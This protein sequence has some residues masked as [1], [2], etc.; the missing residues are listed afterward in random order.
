MSRQ[1]NVTIKDVAKRAKVSV[2]SA[3][4]AINGVGRISQETK[5]RILKAAQELNYVPH[6]GAR[7]LITKKNNIIGV[8]LPD[9]Y[10]EFFSEI[11][12]GID[13]AARLG[14]FNILLSSYHN[15]E[16]E[17][18]TAIA[19]MRGRVDGMVAMFPFETD[20]D[21]LRNTLN[22]PM[23]KIANS[24]SK[25]KIPLIAIDNADGAK[26]AIKHLYDCGKRKIA[27]LSGPKNNL[28]ASDRMRGYRE[29]MDGLEL[30]TN[31]FEGDFR[32]ETG[33]NYAPAI[34]RLVKDGAIDAIFVG[35]DTMA[36]GL[37]NGFKRLGIKIP[38]DVALIGFDTTP[39]ASYITPGLSSMGVDMATLGKRAVEILKQL[40]NND[41]DL[42]EEAHF[43]PVLF[44]RSSSVA[45]LRE[46]E[47]TVLEN[48]TF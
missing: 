13:Y 11:V 40:I 32:E 16:N 19:A 48:L 14:G 41:D 25:A 27:H 46:E 18:K 9:L 39:V 23:V 35:N 38:D 30:K 5:D 28:E 47:M 24:S 33:F 1:G 36:I 8:L 17:T 20:D 45:K 26:T 44:P 12:R 6:F 4:R 43:T 34:A 42:Q 22:A 15:D 10:G 7:S 31:I 21:D 29:A 37:I 2:A 3:S